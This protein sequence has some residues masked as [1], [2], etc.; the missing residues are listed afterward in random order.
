MVNEI[1]HILREL[2]ENVSE[3]LS[4]RKISKIRKINY[5]SAYNAILALEKQGI[6]TLER[7][8]NITLCSF[9]KKFNP[10][11]F[12]VEY[13][14]REELLKNK[15]LKGIYSRL[16]EIKIPY[17]ALLFGSYARGTFTKNSDIDILFIISNNSQ[18]TEIKNTINL[19]PLKIH[20]T[21]ITYKD[22]IQM[23]KSKEFSVVSETV[24]YNKIL[25]GIEEYYRLLDNSK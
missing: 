20:Q 14:R 17:I 1:H 19:I 11:V 15:N 24:K 9:N 10:L 5:K 8:G 3:K 2:I 25:I 13:Q 21:I 7:I 16:K 22:F 4:I 18:E 6:I 12:S 23:A